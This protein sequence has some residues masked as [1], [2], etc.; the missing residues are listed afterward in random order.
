MKK[1]I[2]LSPTSTLHYVKL[3][4]RS[5]LFLL[6]L[7]L[8]I[9]GIAEKSGEHFGGYEDRAIVIYIIFGVYIVEMLLRLFPSKLESMGCEK[10]FGQN[11]IRGAE[12]ERKLL[13]KE[14][15]RQIIPVIISWVLLNGLIAL[16][17][18][19]SLIDS[20]IL[21]LISLFYGVCDMICILFFCPFQTLMM[22]N[23]CCGSCRIYNWDF[24]M[25][26]TPLI[27]VGGSYL[28][29][30][31]IALIIFLKWEITFWLHPER[32]FEE[33]NCALSC[34]NCREKLCSHKTQLRAFLKQREKYVKKLS[35]LG[36]R[37]V[38]YT[39]IGKGEDKENK[40]D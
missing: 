22:K 8:Y 21:M 1:K 19:F 11:Y 16:L 25:M 6:A 9:M 35:R 33:T 10:Q 4:Y 7:F 13:I 34:R 28:I 24:L 26:F 36:G 38:S 31:F 20:G 37:I 3:V 40:K 27:F 39:G 14:G 15:N 23:K 5:V 29:L 17:Y 30:V 18:Y 32:F 12:Y 2:K